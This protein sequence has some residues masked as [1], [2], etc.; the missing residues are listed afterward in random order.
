[1]THT[2]THTTT[3]HVNVTHI[4]MLAFGG[5]QIEDWACN[6]NL[7]SSLDFGVIH[8]LDVVVMR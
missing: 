5:E 7:L 3:V 4:V 6:E 8:G 1:M 2:H